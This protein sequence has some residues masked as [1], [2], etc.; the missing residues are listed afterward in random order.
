MI[1]CVVLLAW[2]AVACGGDDEASD[3]AAAD[4]RA[5]DG[6]IDSGADGAP[7]AQQTITPD[8]DPTLPPRGFYMGVIP[9]PAEGQDLVASHQQAAL[10]A[11][12]SMAH[13]DGSTPFYDLPE[14][15]Q[16]SYLATIDTL[17]RDNGMFPVISVN[18]FGKV[19]ESGVL[20][21]PP[22]LP[23]ATLSDPAWRARYESAVLDV[24]ALARPRYI[25][26]GNEVNFWYD[27]FGDSPESPNGFH[28]YVTLYEDLYDEIKALSPE[29][30]VF[31]VFERERVRDNQEADLSVLELFDPSKL[32]VLA[33]TSYPFALAGVNRPED[34]PD[35]YY[36]RVFDHISER[37]ISFTEL[38]WPSISAFGGEASQAD[39][40]AEMA[41]RLTRDQ[42]LELELFSWWFLHDATTVD[43][44]ATGLIT[45]DGTPRLAYEAWQVL[46]G[47]GS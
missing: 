34:L 19:S 41:G 9:W 25:S 4:A 22:D 44:L 1:A 31:C 17:I 30:Q 32:D 16:D 39:F 26:I 20:V 7:D 6:S 28:H 24:V 46:S 11:E 33:F 3:A 15:Y 13:G 43:P 23:D 12:F 29:T 37:P 42:G 18:F 27:D 2:A 36:S 47:E 5:I 45:S 38:A 14:L 10:Y 40:V 35:D 8:D 21:T